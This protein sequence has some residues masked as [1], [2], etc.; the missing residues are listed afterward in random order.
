MGQHYISLDGQIV[1]ILGA[2]LSYIVSPG[3]FV[4]R[5]VG[6]DVTLEVDVIPLLE[7]P[8]V[9]GGAQVELHVGRDCNKEGN[10]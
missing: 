6:R 4:C 10:T 2:I 1:F 9:H 3:N 8:G 7:V 5:G